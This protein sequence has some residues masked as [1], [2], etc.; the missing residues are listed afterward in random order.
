MAKKKKRPTPPPPP[1]RRKEPAGAAP[2]VTPKQVRAAQRAKAERR[3]RVRRAAITGGLVVAA[4]AAVGGFVALDRRGDAELREA[5]TSGSCTVDTEADVTSPPPGNHVAS[6][7]YRVD[8]PAGGNHLTG[9]ARSGVY[10]GADVPQD[11]LLVHSLEHGYVVVWHDPSL[12][13]AGREQLAA[14]ESDNDGDV[15]V[16][17]RAGMEVPVAA[18]AWEQRL[19]CGGVEPAALQRFADEYVGEGPED[20]ARG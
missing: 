2:G 11:G 4:V 3:D 17:E 12:D 19:L 13:D 7:T 16:V 10:T 15:I 14:F 5:L 1:P 20:V 8:P 18:T 9:N 6:P